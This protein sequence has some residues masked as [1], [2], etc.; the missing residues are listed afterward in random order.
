MH[1]FPHSTLRSRTWGMNSDILISVSILMTRVN[2]PTIILMI[3]IGADNE[4]HVCWLWV[5][6]TPSN[7][8]E[9]GLWNPFR[10][11]LPLSLVPQKLHPQYCSWWHAQKF[12]E[13]M[14]KGGTLQVALLIVILE[15]LFTP[16]LSRPLGTARLMP[17]SCALL[18]YHRAN[19]FLFV[20]ETAFSQPSGQ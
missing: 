17:L 4:A 10:P 9:P 12:I 14:T 3:S 13:W 18:C 1:K 16:G 15:C 5:P 8:N 6:C 19:I 11:T 7:L 2:L 20:M